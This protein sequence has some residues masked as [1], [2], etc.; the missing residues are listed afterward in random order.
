MF[1]RPVNKRATATSRPSVAHFY[2]VDFVLGGPNGGIDG[3]IEGGV[4]DDDRGRGQRGGGERGGVSILFFWGD[5][6]NLFFLSWFEDADSPA[7]EILHRTPRVFRYS[8][9]STSS[10]QPETQA[11]C[12]VGQPIC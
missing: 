3:W 10:D 9:G 6:S 4:R 8:Q 5:E 2:L 12:M 1:N 7:Q 11:T